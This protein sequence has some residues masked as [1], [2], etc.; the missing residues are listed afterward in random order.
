MCKEN[1]KN[2]LGDDVPSVYF[3][4]VNLQVSFFRER[5][6]LSE[7]KMIRIFIRERKT[8]TKRGKYIF[9]TQIH[10][11]ER[12]EMGQKDLERYNAL[13]SR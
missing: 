8:N 10:W 9:Y 5:G 2:I 13:R 12:T 1:G 6:T 3:T 4:A 11:R 7:R